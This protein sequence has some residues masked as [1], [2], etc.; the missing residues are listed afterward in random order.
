MFRCA[1]AVLVAGLALAGCGGHDKAGGTPATGTETIEVAMRDGS[2]R[3]LTAY[4][5]TV[6]RIAEAPTRIKPRTGWRSQELNPEAR[7]I[8]DVRSG[9]L[10]FA[11]VSA[12][13]FDTVGV[14][15]FAPMLA[16]LAVDSLETERRVLES[17][18]ADR[19]LS[20]IG[21]LGL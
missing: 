20:A 4:A 9:R 10:E 12:R 17:G 19:A 8:A 14:D 15:A 13:A 1:A 3:L 6:A 11:L 21:R 18:L 16:P 5:D 7:T 2:P